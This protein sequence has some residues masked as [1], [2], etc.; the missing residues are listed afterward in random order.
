MLVINADRHTYIHTINTTK[1]RLAK[2]IPELACPLPSRGGNQ[3]RFAENSS[4]RSSTIKTATIEMKL[5][6]V[7]VD[8]IL[9]TDYNC[10][11]H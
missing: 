10:L 6:A 7:L 1:G 9:T 3:A 11:I 5:N 4:K 2:N 8:R